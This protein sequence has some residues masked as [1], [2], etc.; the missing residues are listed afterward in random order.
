[1]GVRFACHHCGKRLNIK[2]E[3]AG[4]RGVC[5]ACSVR[6]RIPLADAEQSI[7]LSEEQPA[8]E[9][10]PSD[11]HRA[12]ASAATDA[13][14]GASGENA[15]SVATDA[16]PGRAVAASGSVAASDWLTGDASATW[17]VRP[18]SGGQYGPATSEVLRQWIEEGRLAASALVWRDGWP[19]WRVAHEAFP[20]LADRLPGGGDPRDRSSTPAATVGDSAVGL[21]SDSG[22]AVPPSAVADSVLRGEPSVGAQRQQRSLRRVTVIGLLVAVSVVL[23]AGLAVILLR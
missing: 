12:G 13:S 19:Q 21:G 6:F 20:D 5:P 14:T 22:S 1:M 18:P 3:L 7:P 4:K 10:R 15:G 11:R 2:R 9:Q 16:Q 23:I 17:Y 8:A